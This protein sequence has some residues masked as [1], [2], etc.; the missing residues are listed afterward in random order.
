M[1]KFG[2]EV[3][4]EGKVNVARKLYFLSVGFGGQLLVFGLIS[5]LVLVM[6][7]AMDG[8]RFDWGFSGF[9]NWIRVISGAFASFWGGVICE[10]VKDCTE[11]NGMKK[12]LGTIFRIFYNRVVPRNFYDYQEFYKF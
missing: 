11:E 10:I 4:G 2:K 9:Y 7:A 8:V 5:R 12:F 6:C 3:N 1:S